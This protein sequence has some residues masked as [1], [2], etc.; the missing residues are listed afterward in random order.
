M[1]IRSLLGQL[2]TV[3]AGSGP[4][5]ADCRH[6]RNDRESVEQAFPGLSSMGS[7]GADVRAADGL[8]SLHGTYLAHTDR[9]AQFAARLP[10][11]ATT[12]SK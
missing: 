6:F 7:Y 4:R 12:A 8:C 2:G 10:P 5:C 9:C 3:G 1:G 11:A